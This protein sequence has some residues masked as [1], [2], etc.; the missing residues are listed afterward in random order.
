MR[1]D[2]VLAYGEP[3]PSAV[4]EG[5][6][7]TG[8]GETKTGEKTG[9]R[10]G[11][12]AGA[13]TGSGNDEANLPC[14]Q[15]LFMDS[16]GNDLESVAGQVACGC[17]AIFFTTGNGSITNFPFVPTIK[18]VTT[19]ERFEYLERDMDFNAGEYQKGTPMPDLG[20][21]LFEHLLDISGGTRCKGELANHSQVSIWRDWAHDAHPGGEE[22]K[23]GQEGR[24]EVEVEGPTEGT[25]ETERVGGGG[26]AGLATTKEGAAATAM[27]DTVPT[28]AA[29]LP[30]LASLETPRG[31]DT[32]VYD[33]E[34]LRLLDEGPASASSEG[35]IGLILP[36]SL[37]SSQVAVQIAAALNERLVQLHGTTDEDGGGGGRGIDSGTSVSGGAG[38]GNDNSFVGD[39]GIGSGHGGESEHAGTACDE[40]TVSAAALRGFRRF[41]ALP[42]T[43]GCGSMGGLDIYD[44]I[45]VGHLLHPSVRRAA[46]LEHGCEKCHND[47]MRDALVSRLTSTSGGAALGAPE[48]AAEVDRRFGWFSIQGAGGITAATGDV[49]SWFNGV[50]Q[51]DQD[52]GSGE[53]GGGDTAGEGE[54]GGRGGEVTVVNDAA[55]GADAAGVGLWQHLSIA[56]L[57]T[58]DVPAEIAALFAA[59]SVRARALG[60]TVIVPRSCSLLDGP[61][62]FLDEALEGCD[63]GGWR[64]GVAPATVAF[65]EPPQN[66]P[67]TTGGGTASAGASGSSVGTCAPMGDLVFMESPSPGESADWVDLVVG[68]AGAGADLIITHSNHL[69]QPH[70]FV[71]MLRVTAGVRGGEG[72]GAE[73]GVA[74]GV[75]AAA[76]AAGSDFVVGVGGMDSV[77]DNAEAR[78]EALLAVVKATLEHRH[79]PRTPLQ[80]A[81]F[82]I[83]R[84]T[85]GVSV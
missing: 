44:R 62:C 76:E 58:D 28:E 51:D 61:C 30:P 67:S 39:V 55:A 71:P 40:V 25:Q 50:G 65:A 33:N 47:Y 81:D 22:T 12:K 31:G 11:E 75:E 4:L 5:C 3:R 17:N 32:S 7:G 48:A 84:G 16:P 36:T 66:A 59:V 41:V 9:N 77:V 24:G 52:E 6:G 70:P 15:Y 18:V 14:G 74:A 82:A 43:E 80:L 35:H 38:G 63:G 42:H 20:Q 54:D 8:E 21:K 68:L 13:E 2:G 1:L 60:A 45:M 23:N 26:A 69:R 53:E 56:L 85:F 49:R 83:A 46:V 79:E 37:C 19:S 72:G 57:S 64:K 34:L 27:V 10:T 29:S 73:A 78:T